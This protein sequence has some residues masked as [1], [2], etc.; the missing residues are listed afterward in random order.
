MWHLVHPSRKQVLCETLPLRD[1]YRLKDHGILTD[2]DITSIVETRIGERLRPFGLPADRVLGLIKKY[3]AI[4]SGSFVLAILFPGLFDPKDMDFFVS[5]G[6]HR[7]LMKALRAWGFT[8]WFV[9]VRDPSPEEADASQASDCMPEAQGTSPIDSEEDAAMECSDQEYVSDSDESMDYS[10]GAK[11]GEDQSD[12]D[13]EMRGSDKSGDSGAD[14]GDYG[15]NQGEDDGGDEEGEEEEEEEDGD[16]IDDEGADEAEGDSDDEVVEDG[17]GG[18]E[19][20]V[21]E[22]SAVETDE[23]GDQTEEDGDEE[24]DQSDEESNDDE[25]HED[26]EDE[27]EEDDDEDEEDDDDDDGDDNGDEDADYRDSEDEHDERQGGAAKNGCRGFSEGESEDAGSES[28]AEETASEWQESSGEDENDNTQK[29]QSRN[30]GPQ[31][32]KNYYNLQGIRRVFEVQNPATGKTINIVESSEETP[33][34]PLAFFHCSLVMN[35]I[36]FHGLVILH[37]RTTVEG[38]GLKN[39]D[40]GASEPS[41]KTR[42]ALKKYAERGFLIV[43]SAKEREICGQHACNK[44]FACPGTDRDLLDEGVIHIPFTPYEHKGKERLAQLRFAEEAR[45]ADFRW[46]LTSRNECTAILCQEA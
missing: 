44:S 35:Y 10:D 38:I 24:S 34:E 19:D 9:W 20:E 26:D 46:R 31:S 37:P 30:G 32:M 7:L 12:S 18:V 8:E 2:E 1:L 15:S 4:I 21:S 6:A 42:D 13:D 16:D 17:E 22:E 36:A 29:P 23:E 41:T 33:L 28:E 45:E 14:D 5:P 39:Y 25:D 40:L 11:E 27:D 43:E 3:G